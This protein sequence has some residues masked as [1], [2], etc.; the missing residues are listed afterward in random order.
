M[1]SRFMSAGV[2]HA[3]EQLDVREFEAAGVSVDDVTRTLEVEGVQK[4]TDSFE[5]LLEGIR[6]KRGEL[7]SA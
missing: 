1:S 2:P 5:E 4:F 7:V 6:A 3:L